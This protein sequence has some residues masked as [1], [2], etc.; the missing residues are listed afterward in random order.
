MMDRPKKGFSIPI[1][2]WLRNELRE[3]VNEQINYTSIQQYGI[4]NTKKVMELKRD[5]EQGKLYNPEIIW[6]LLVFQ[7]WLQKWM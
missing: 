5:W 2:Q 7:L 3:L 1:N 6:Q 4:L